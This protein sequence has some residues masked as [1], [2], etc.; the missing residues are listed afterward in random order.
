MTRLLSKEIRLAMHPTNLIF[1]S[2]SALIIIPNYP[3][4]V[5]FFYTA[6]GIFFT[7]LT[8][9]ENNDIYYTLLLPVPKSEA[10]KGRFAFTVLLEAAQLLLAIPFAILRNGFDMPANQ[11]GIMPN[12]AFF[13]LAMV[14]LGLF[15]LVFFTGYYKAPDKVGKSFV[16]ATVVIFLYM[17]AA[18][19][20]VHFPGIGAIN[21]AGA[22]NM[23]L[24]LI[25]LA[26]G[27]ALFIVLTLTAYS[28]SKRSFEALDL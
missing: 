5:T 18:E 4:Y 20:L 2:L 11:V 12:P 9:R 16:I 23:G 1:L 19:V 15:N 28:L 6:L 24:K 7:C 25:V 21:G 14:M 26:A 10:V 3:Y 13:G 22:E 8:G 17:I 27:A